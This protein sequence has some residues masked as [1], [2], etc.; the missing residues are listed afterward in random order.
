VWLRPDHRGE[1]L[2]PIIAA[3]VIERLG[4]GCELAA[5]YPAPFEGK[6]E[7]AERAASVEALGQIWAKA[8]F[9]L[10]SDGVW[11]LDPQH[12]DSRRALAKLVAERSA[13]LTA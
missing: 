7:P 11:M 1:G 9:R 12:H 3:A 13:L 6:C 10:W 5:C 8:G 4:R 2:G